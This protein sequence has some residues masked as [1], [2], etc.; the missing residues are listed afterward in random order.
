MIFNIISINITHFLI[1]SIY[2]YIF[3]LKLFLSLIK[4]IKF[5]NYN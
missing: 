4:L 5:M 1:Y 3:K 2:D